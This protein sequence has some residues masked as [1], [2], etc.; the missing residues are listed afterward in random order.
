V[1]LTGGYK[2]RIPWTPQLDAW[3]QANFHL[4]RA[5]HGYAGSHIYEKNG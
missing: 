5:L 3:F 4:V 1:W 2:S